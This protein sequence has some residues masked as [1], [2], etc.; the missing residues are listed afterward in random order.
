MSAHNRQHHCVSKKNKVLIDTLA[1]ASEAALDKEYSYGISTPG[2]FGNT[3]NIQ[4][5]TDLLKALESGERDIEVLADISHE[6]WSKIARKFD[7][8]IYKSQPEKRAKRL[9]LAETPYAELPEDEKE[10]D[11][12]AAKAV[13][14]AYLKFTGGGS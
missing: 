9:K 8:P 4:S 12:V 13:L 11:R 7:D 10:K 2:S 14:K 5:A 1:M 3:C 6:G